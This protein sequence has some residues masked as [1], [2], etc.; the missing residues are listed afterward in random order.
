VPLFSVVTKENGFH[1]PAG[2]NISVESTFAEF[3]PVKTKITTTAI[4]LCAAISIARL[5]LNLPRG[6][7]PVAVVASG[8]A[9]VLASAGVFLKPRFSYCLGVVSGLVAL[10]WFSE[11]EFGYFPALNSWITFNLPDGNPYFFSDIFLAKLK[12]LFAATAVASTACSATRLLPASWALRRFPVRERTWPALALSFL[13]IASWYGFSVSPYRIPLFVHGVPPELAV[14]HVEKRGTQFHETVISTFRDGKLYVERNDRRL[15][16]YRF[17]V[18]GGSEVLPD[19]MIARVRMLAQSTQLRDMRT[20]P[21]VALRNKNAEGWYVR[22][23]RSV[24]AFTSEYGTEPPKEIVDLF[25]DLESVV[26]AKRESRA[27]NDICMGFCY[28]PLAGLGLENL[29]DRC[30]GRNWTRCK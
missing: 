7:R 18:C 22:T 29:N 11:I 27:V 16:Q 5:L 3:A 28:D 23:G 13:V 1:D 26:P 12:I 15:F 25:R 2:V 8:I 10:R 9:F 19:G 20:A 6:D 14:L 21:A 17:A 30:A 4:F 24:L